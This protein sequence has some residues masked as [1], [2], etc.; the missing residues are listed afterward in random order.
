MGLEDRGQYSIVTCYL[1]R[2]SD[3]MAKQ[4]ENWQKS[5]D[6]AVQ[7]VTGLLRSQEEL[8]KR[9]IEEQQKKEAEFER[10]M[11]DKRRQVLADSQ[12]QKAEIKAGFQKLEDEK[13][14]MEGV[15]K[16]QSSRVKL[17][18]GGQR[19]TTSRSTLTKQSDTMLAVMFSGRHELVQ[20]EDGTYFID[21]DGT[22][23]RHVL[24]FL[25]DGDSSTL[26][27]DR[28]ALKELMKEAEFYQIGSLIKAI[29][30][31][32]SPKPKLKLSQKQLRSRLGLQC[33]SQGSVFAETSLT[34]T[35]A[36]VTLSDL[37]LTGLSFAGI[38]FNHTC[39]FKGSILRNASFSR[40]I[41]AAKTDLSDTDLTNATF[42]RCQ[43]LLDGFVDFTGA[44]HDGIKFDEEIIH[45]I[46]F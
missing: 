26:P 33:T 17:D 12:E 29:R 30:D 2:H 19:F 31:V 15:Y 46:R 11:A 34:S 28:Y 7:T 24:N 27:D 40:C 8:L 14:A 32:L 38:R 20:E 5:F 18:V 44:I 36:N 45:Q 21:R 6:N 39:S 1:L 3:T 41:F 10:D 35:T 13:K 16:F 9:R 42:T 43:G 37:D 22:H 23:F 25:R 4:V